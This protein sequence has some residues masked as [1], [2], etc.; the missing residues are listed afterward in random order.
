MR[1]TKYLVDILAEAETEEDLKFAF[2]KRLNLNPS[3]K[4][5]IDLYTE[6][7]LFEFKLNA[8]FTHLH[9]RA[10]VIAQALYYIRRLKFG[11]DERPLSQ[12]IC[13]VSKN[14]G[15]L[16]PTETF[17]AFYEDDSFD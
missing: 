11:R 9:T 7:V 2:I 8:D 6:Q 15:A 13:V 5:S 16:F 10:K 17:A 12:N 1:K 14:F 4:K 3:S